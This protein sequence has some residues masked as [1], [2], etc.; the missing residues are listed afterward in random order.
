MMGWVRISIVAALASMTM[1]CAASLGW[2]WSEPRFV[3]APDAKKY[4][5][6]DAVYLLREHRLL[7]YQEWGKDSYTERQRHDVVAI[8]TEKGFRYANFRIIYPNKNSALIAFAART[9]N[10]DGT[11]TPLEPEWVFD[12]EV[13]GDEYGAKVR[14]FTFPNVKVGSI[15]EVQYTL[16]DDYVDWY[17]APYVTT[18]IPIEKYHLEL[19]GTKSVRYSVNAYNIE[20]GSEWE[21]SVEGDY[22]RLRWQMSDVPA[23]KGGER[24]EPR[25]F[26]EPWWMFTA[27]AYQS[28]ANLYEIHK[29]WDSTVR[30]RAKGLYDEDGEYYEGFDAEVDDKDCTNKKC[31]VQAA[32]DFLRAEL[33][34]NWFNGGMGRKAK[35]V[36]DSKKADNWEKNRVLW[37]LLRRKKIESLYVLTNRK[38][39]V[40]FDK[41]QPHYARLKHILLWVPKQTGIEEGFFVDASCEFCT[42]GQVPDW[43]RGEEGFVVGVEKEGLSTENT[44]K[45][46]WKKIVGAETLPDVVH[47]EYAVT[48]DDAGKLTAKVR[49]TRGGW[50]AQWWRSARR[51][52]KADAAKR[53]AERMVNRRDERGKL[54]SDSRYSF[55]PDG[56]LG[57]RTIEFEIPDYGVRDKERLII[58]LSAL[59]T[60]FD[61]AFKKKSRDEPIYFD[62][63]ATWEERLA[64]RGPKGYAPT[65]LFPSKTIDAGAVKVDVKV[66]TEGDIV[67]IERSVH[68][69]EGTYAAAKYADIRDAIELY[70]SVDQGAIVFAKPVSEPL[71]PSAAR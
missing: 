21:T 63:T 25:D 58:P 15:L 33:Y 68:H 55:E 67:I 13:K 27:L 42:V 24:V 11:A 51:N 71:A 60:P 17:E 8:L 50:G 46:E 37:E 36:M 35:E 22:W 1:S 56:S 9:I 65:I 49:Q 16:R 69:R 28:S 3:K 26:R 52:Q 23:S 12:D 44:Y 2:Q 66:R 53:E 30:Y 39:H 32:L 59:D 41:E 7:M 62:N 10:E 19:M 45:G 31:Q 48:V 6:H 18:D 14:V 70:R 4:D 29:D 64:V 57:A 61:N 5:G 54:I 40:S 43:V 38:G 34:F 20:E 47:K